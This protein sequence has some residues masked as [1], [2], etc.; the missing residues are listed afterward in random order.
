[1]RQNS[2]SKT[3]RKVDLNILTLSAKQGMEQVLLSEPTAPRL[4][5]V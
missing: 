2:P 1:M 4:K 3:A 5:K